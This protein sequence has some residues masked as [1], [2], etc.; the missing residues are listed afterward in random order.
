MQQ[1]VCPK[2]CSVNEQDYYDGLTVLHRA[3]LLNKIEFVKILT[4][5][6]HGIKAGVYM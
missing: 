5:D 1:M 6:A 2:N 3:A 4:E